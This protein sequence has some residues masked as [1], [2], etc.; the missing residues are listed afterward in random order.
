MVELWREITFVTS[1]LFSCIPIIR[2]VLNWAMAQL[3]IL[4]TYAD[5]EGPDQPAHSHSLIRAFMSAYKI[6]NSM[7]TTE[8][9]EE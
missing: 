8:C 7:E 5:N 4:I 1:C 9:V 6:Y 2:K 3:M